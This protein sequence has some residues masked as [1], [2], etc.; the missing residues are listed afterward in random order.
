MADAVVAGLVRRTPLDHAHRSLGARFR[1]VSGWEM[2]ASYGSVEEERDA[3]ASAGGI[4]D[5][6]HIGKLV[7]QGH[8]LLS[9]LRTMF[10]VET[11]EPGSVHLLEEDADTTARIAMLTADEVIVLASP[12]AID[13]TRERVEKALAGCAHVTDVTSARAGLRVLGPQSHRVLSKVVEFDID[14][15]VFPAD[16]CAQGRAAGTHVLLVRANA[17]GAPCYELYVTRDHS[18]HLWDALVAA[19]RADGVGPVGLDAVESALKVG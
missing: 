18:E 10:G 4:C 9:G 13:H 5:L 12:S 16:T 15:R 1:L 6:S 17:A 7:A 2:P 3:L 11:L 8:D 14:P 19:G